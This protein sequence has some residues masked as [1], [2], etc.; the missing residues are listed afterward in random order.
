M[1]DDVIRSDMIHKHAAEYHHVTTTTCRRSTNLHYGNQPFLTPA[2]ADLTH[3]FSNTADAN[4]K[5]FNSDALLKLKLHYSIFCTQQ[6]QVHYESK[7]LATTKP[8]LLAM[9]RLEMLW[10]SF[11][12]NNKSATNRLVIAL[13]P[14]AGELVNHVTNYVGA[15]HYR[16]KS[17]LVQSRIRACVSML[18]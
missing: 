1:T 9:S 16:G 10:I 4:R 14:I 15:H 3:F 12:L 6:H 13:Q 17:K 7:G 11:R 5:Q 2:S 18:V 8:Q